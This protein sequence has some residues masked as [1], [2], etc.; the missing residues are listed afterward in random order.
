[1]HAVAQAG[2]RCIG[3]AL[4]VPLLLL[5]L[6][7]KPVSSPTT[8]SAL[9]PQDA[10]IG[11]KGAFADDYEPDDDAAPAPASWVLPACAGSPIPRTATS[12]PP[13]SRIAYRPRARSPPRLRA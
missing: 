12:S 7:A 11:L 5:L 1:M 6:G 4:L 3:F 8:N 13:S 9:L 2:W 10:D